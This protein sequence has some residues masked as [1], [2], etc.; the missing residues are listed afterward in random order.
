LIDYI[1]YCHIAQTRVKRGYLKAAMNDARRRGAPHTGRRSCFY[2]AVSLG[3][4]DAVTLEFRDER[5][6]DPKLI[7][8]GKT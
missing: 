7:Y 4:D 3:K 2:R 5:V 6:L 1:F 8:A